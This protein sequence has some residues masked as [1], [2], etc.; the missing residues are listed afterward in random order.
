MANAIPDEMLEDP[1]EPT[2]R[3]MQ[4][5]DR[6]VQKAADQM[7]I[8][9][10]ELLAQ[11]A[12]TR[13]EQEELQQMI[14]QMTKNQLFQ[15]WL[16]Q[17]M[18]LQYGE[19]LSVQQQTIDELQERMDKEYEKLRTAFFLHPTKACA[20][21]YQQARDM[22]H[23]TYT[24]IKDAFQ[25]LKKFFTRKATETKTA[26]RDGAAQAKQTVTTKATAA[27][28]QMTEKAKTAKTFAEAQALKA[29]EKAK[30]AVQKGKDAA[31]AVKDGTVHAAQTAYQTARDADAK[32]A[33][34]TLSGVATVLGSAADRLSR[35]RDKVETISQQFSKNNVI[36]IDGETKNLDILRKLQQQNGQ[37]QIPYRTSKGNLHMDFVLNPSVEGEAPTMT[38]LG[39]LPIHE[40]APDRG[41]EWWGFFDETS[42][43]FDDNKAVLRQNVPYPLSKEQLKE[44]SADILDSLTETRHV[45]AA[46]A[47]SQERT[48]DAS[49]DALPQEES[50][51]IEKPVQVRATKRNRK[52][53]TR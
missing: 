23:E 37:I 9:K 45:D 49:R 31:H 29:E 14:A 33:E 6:N 38:V 51:Q 43:S 17:Q 16:Q 28:T 32:L 4:A 19:R 21:L 53:V 48:R 36:V 3:E 20:K 47:Q 26:I 1:A 15:Q 46:L 11:D 25:S 44:V 18:E 7:G 52:P 12:K 40:N 2:E 27:K 41:Y 50:F 39:G 35:S 10:E 30:A 8:S 13:K 42:K 24:K 5:F 22:V 34:K